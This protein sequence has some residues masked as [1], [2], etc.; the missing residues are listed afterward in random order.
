MS[1]VS[2]MSLFESVLTFG[3]YLRKGRFTNVGDPLCIS[4]SA[5]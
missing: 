2:G 1:R 4:A 3:P 5:L